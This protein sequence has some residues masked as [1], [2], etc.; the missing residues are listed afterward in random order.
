VD[1]IGNKPFIEFVEQLE[2]DEDLEL[3]TVDLDKEPVV[4]QSIFPDPEKQDK[5]IVIPV[6][7]P[8]L[9]RKK[10]LAEEIAAIDVSRIKAPT[11]PKKQGDAAS[12]AFH[13]DGYDILTLEKLVEREYTIPEVQT[14]QEVISYYAK[15]IAADLKLPS[16]FAALVP[17]VRE[18]LENHAF[19]ERVDLD[20]PAMIKAISYPVTQ[21]VT[22]K[23]FVTLLRDVLVEELTPVLEQAGRP[24]STCEPFPWSR[25]VAA[26]KKTVFNLVAAD[27]QFEKT[28][29]EFL[30]KAGD[31][32]R[33]SKLPERFGFTVA[34]TDSAAN[35]RYYEPDFVAV[36][37]D[38]IHHL[39]ETKGREDVDVAHKDRAAGL[40]CEN[41]T[42][43]TDTEWRYKKVPQKEFE[44]LGPDDF[45][46]LIALEP[47]RL[48]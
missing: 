14:P 35:L 9:A 44:K 2:K 4:I 27:N 3:G 48:L 23:A 22:V 19:G 12:K 5:D 30:E 29:A 16:Q 8:L 17:K 21:H 36:T 39:I 1:V 25:P 40:W 7:S 13:Y 47:V 18:F 38:G 20:D 26:A 31:V 15:R 10:T 41:A 43:L 32:E 37:A 28:F 24:L 34:Y 11:L 6:L 33:F 45:D 42:L 46:D